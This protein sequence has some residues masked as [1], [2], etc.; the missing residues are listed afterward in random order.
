[1]AYRPTEAKAYKAGNTALPLYKLLAYLY[2]RIP[3]GWPMDPLGSL[4]LLDWSSPALSD[5]K[6]N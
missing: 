6:N 3:M 4:G 1:M 5:N 2:A